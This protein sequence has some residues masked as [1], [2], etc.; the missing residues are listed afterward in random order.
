MARCGCSGATCS[1]VIQGQGGINV[2]GA[3]SVANPYVLTSDINLGIQDSQTVNLSLTGDGSD[4]NPWVLQADATM[5]LDDLVDVDA[6]VMTNGYV[7]A[8]QSDGTFALVPPTTAAVG[9]I[10]VGNGLQGDGSAGNALRVLLAPS[11]GLIVDGTG[12]R[13]SGGGAWSTYTPVWTCATTNGSLGNGSIEG[14]YSQTGKTVNV[15]FE[16]TIGSTTKRGVGTYRFTLPVPPATNRR[17][18]LNANV[19]REGVTQYIGSAV[20]ATN[21]VDYIDIANSTSASHLSHSSPATLPVGS[22]ITFTGVY[23]AA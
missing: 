9:A 18:M 14:Y 19:R 22:L 1:C 5:H 23:E 8:R 12:L 13:I 17:Q 10:T 20:I 16:M 11:S 3:G 6:T 21:K 2:T 15:S 4:A 7:V